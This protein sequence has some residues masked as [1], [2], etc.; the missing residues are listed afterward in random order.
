MDPLTILAS[1]KAANEGIKQSIA[2]GRDIMDT[3]KQLSD[4]MQGVADLTK[5]TVDPPKGFG[6]HGSA[7]EIALKAFQAKKEAEEIFATYKNQVIAEHGINEWEKLQRQII[8]TRKRL[9]AEAIAAAQKKS[10]DQLFAAVVSF[11]LIGIAITVYLVYYAL[12]YH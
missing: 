6:S 11:S 2:L 5:L 10:E 8:D 1:I 9:K 7:E 12:N 3:A 4:I